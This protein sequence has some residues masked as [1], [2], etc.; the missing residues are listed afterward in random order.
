MRSH[1]IRVLAQV[2]A[3]RAH[4]PGKPGAIK[5]MKVEQGEEA[6][7]VL[8]YANKCSHVFRQQAPSISI[9]PIPASIVT[10]ANCHKV[11]IQSAH[12][13]VHHSYST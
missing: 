12:F 13:H 2:M 9:G 8:M 11:R 5:K 3:K 4:V 6:S 10:F 7:H 1:D